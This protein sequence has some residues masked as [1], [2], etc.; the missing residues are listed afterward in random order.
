LI[1]CKTTFDHVIQ[2]F[3]ALNH[4]ELKVL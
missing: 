1:H 2:T 4:K 3:R